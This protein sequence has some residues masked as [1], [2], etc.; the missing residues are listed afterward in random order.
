M[1]MLTQ[2][3]LTIIIMTFI[4]FI[5]LY[6]PRIIA[7]FGS[8]KKQARITNEKKNKIAI[9]IPARNE[10]KVIKDLLL[11]LKN[12]SYDANYFDPYVIVKEKD[13]PTIDICKEFGYNYMVVSW[14][15][16]KSDALDFC[17]K[18]LINSSKSYDSFYIVDADCLLD[19]DCLLELNNAM[20]SN[21]EIIQSKK[22]VKNYLS[23]NKE[24]KT[25][26][27]TCN[28][29]IWTLIDDMGNRYKSDHKI[30]NMTIGTGVMLRSDLVKKLNGWPYDQT[31]TEDIELMYDCVFRGIKTF[32]Y[33]YSKIYVEEANTLKVTN[34]RRN[35]WLD[36]LI[37]SRFLY[38]NRIDSLFKSPNNLLNLYYSQACCIP[39]FF[40]GLLT[41]YSV[42]L[43]TTSLILF[44]VN[45]PLWLSLLTLSTFSFLLIYF[46][47]FMMTLIA[48]I[49]DGK[50]MTVS[51]FKKILTLFIHPFF[52]MGYIVI[53]AK[54]YLN[55]KREAKW[56]SIDRI[57]FGGNNK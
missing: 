44:I 22:I 38:K 31:L 50:Y 13:D 21:C 6:L 37:N 27:V 5:I 3:L 54:V 14:Q 43:G 26:A 25:L 10:S 18:S 53:V 47:F 9:V 8:F 7:W 57:D 15:K 16:K 32:Y 48:L 42:S 41:F 12:Q 4:L 11:S 1:N 17:L 46:S 34:I 51:L 36:G 30:T 35:R 2:V 19:K 55:I 24:N 28:G 45:N 52:Y 33:S 23:D 56:I 20:A 29:I 49:I 39:Y 40:I